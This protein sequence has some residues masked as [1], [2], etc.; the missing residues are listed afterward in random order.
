MSRR[1]L[2]VLCAVGMFACSPS[3]V[4]APAASFPNQFPVPT[5]QA[6][7]AVVSIDGFG[8]WTEPDPGAG[9]F[10]PPGGG[11]GWGML[12]R[13]GGAN[14]G[15]AGQWGTSFPNPDPR[16]AG[17]PGVQITARADCPTDP[18]PSDEVV[19]DWLRRVNIQRRDWAGA[20][21]SPFSPNA[22]PTAEE[23]QYCRA[24]VGQ[25]PTPEEFADLVEWSELSC[26]ICFEALV[27]AFEAWGAWQSA[28]AVVEI[29]QRLLRE[30]MPCGKEAVI[31]AVGALTNFT[32]GPAGVFGQLVWTRIAPNGALLGTP[33]PGSRIGR[34]LPG[35]LAAAEALFAE[36]EVLTGAS[37]TLITG[38]TDKW[39]LRGAD[40]TNIVL[41][42]TSASGPPAID[43]NVPGRQIVK[44]KFP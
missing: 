2:A 24:R 8:M 5:T 28:G 29:G 14:C 18:F 12:P 25:A 37:R 17:V 44:Y 9:W 33:H 22:A 16:F 3:D 10:T 20:G 40:G 38:S 39:I 36:L 42:L 23:A 4:S 34:N 15:P 6:D 31:M 1:S 7:T 30:G 32:K 19:L 43:I 11:G 41:R 21:W 26:P 27:M 13:L 35:G